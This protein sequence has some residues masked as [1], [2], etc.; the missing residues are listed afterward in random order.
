M[1]RSRGLL[2]YEALGAL[3]AGEIAPLI[4]PSGCFNVKARRLKAF[5]DFLGQEYGGRLDA[6]EVEEP[7]VLRGK[8]LAVPGIGPETAD[9]IALYAAGRGLFVIDA[10]TRRVFSRLGAIRGDEPYDVLQRLFMDAV[11]AD[12]ELYG[13]Y[14]AQ[15]V[16]LAKDV[17]ANAF[18]KEAIKHHRVTKTYQA[19]ALDLLSRGQSDLFAL[20]YQGIDEVS[21]RFAHF[22]DP[23]MDMV[24]EADH[25]RF[26]NAVQAFYI[27]QDQQ[28]SEILSRV[29][30]AS[31]VIVI[32]DHGFK[33][34]ASRPVDHPPDLEGQP[35]RWHRNYGIFLAS[36]PMV[37]PGEKDTLSLLDI[38]PTILSAAGLPA[39]AEP[40]I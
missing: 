4:R 24:S 7:R 17:E 29:D 6:M 21:H 40:C 14:H 33:S 18:V 23:K 9:S 16:L 5:L 28:L 36:G 19:I 20:Y 11:P 32:S 39:A 1:L 37:T 22:A 10:Y 34:G 8:L 31:L 13:D 26:R 3:S 30:P 12:T 35:A 2:S 25:A 27:Y 15:I 38:A